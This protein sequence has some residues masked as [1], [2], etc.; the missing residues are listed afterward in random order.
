[1]LKRWSFLLILPLLLM[2]CGTQQ[3]AT[4]DDPAKLGWDDVTAQARGTTVNMHMWGGDQAINRYMSEWVA[5]RLKTE[6]DVTLQITPL[7]DTTEAV[8]KLVGEK[9]ANKQTGGTIDMVWVNGENFRTLRQG[10]LLY[11]PWAQQL[12]SA[13]LIPWS[14]PSVANDFG[15]PVDGYEAPW[16]RAQWVMIYDS[17]RV[18]E[19]PRSWDALLAWAKAHLGASPTRHRPISAVRRLCAKRFSRRWTI[20]NSCRAR[21]T[22]KCTTPLHRT[23]GSISTS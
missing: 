22:R 20:P 23:Y 18:P 7:G 15:Y 3:T 17:V 6:H 12:P 2:A 10:N 11:G 4:N 14:D 9:T 19:P 21:S 1:M 5:T 8:N 16:G 13:E